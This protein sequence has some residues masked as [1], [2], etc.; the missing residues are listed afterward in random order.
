MM[1]RRKFT[2]AMISFFTVICSP[3][4]IASAR[5]RDSLNSGSMVLEN[6][7][8]LVSEN[9]DSL[10]AVGDLYL[11][12]HPLEADIVKLSGHVFNKQETIH[13]V[14]NMTS[15]DLHTWLQSRSCHD[16]AHGRIVDVKG[17]QLSITEARFCGLVS[18]L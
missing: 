11:R 17:W 12:D 16:F 4:K 13:I 2:T 7:S 3:V 15:N 6:L 5:Q 1:T 9:R 14:S 18:M 10:V 8:E